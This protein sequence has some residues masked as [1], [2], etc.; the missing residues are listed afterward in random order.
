M[1][2][3][4]LSRSFGGS[5]VPIQGSD[6]ATVLEPRNP[7]R[8]TA[9]RALPVSTAMVGVPIRLDRGSVRQMHWHKTAEWSYVLAGQAWITSV[10]EDGRTFGAD[11]G[12]GD[13]RCFLPGR[14]HSIQG[15]GE[16][17]V[18]FLLVFD[19]GSFSKDSTALI[20][21]MFAHLPRDVLARNFGW[22]Q[23]TL[24]GI[25]DKEL[26]VFQMALPTPRCRSTAPSARTLGQ[27]PRASVRPGPDQPSGGGTQG[28]RVGVSW[29]SRSL[30]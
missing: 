30:R 7:A 28:N 25:P 6:G 3:V 13:L 15:T 16:D 10:D 9:G 8:E 20:S 22:P 24:A 4:P 21:D 17:G 11:M 23:A 29:A 5:F 1:S 18:E 19:D 26:Y 2:I 14:P 27:G 12:V